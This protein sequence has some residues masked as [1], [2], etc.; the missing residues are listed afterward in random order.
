MRDVITFIACMAVFL[1]CV[2]F[3]GCMKPPDAGSPRPTPD[4]TTPDV[5]DDVKPQ[6]LIADKSQYYAGLARLL[7]RGACKS[8]EDF[9]GTAKQARENLGLPAGGEGV[10]EA[11]GDLLA[12]VTQPL[13]DTLRRKLIARLVKL[14][15]QK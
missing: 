8:V 9:L 7:E 11:F 14:A 12:D 1:S 5:I 6:P 4:D 10:N 15:D 3:Q 13:D 2:A